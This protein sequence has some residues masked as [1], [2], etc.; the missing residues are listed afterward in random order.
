MVKRFDANVHCQWYLNYNVRE[1][2]LE[3]LEV[4]KHESVQCSNNKV[5]IKVPF[6]V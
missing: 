5:V 6:D 1:S 4:K 2:N 3:D